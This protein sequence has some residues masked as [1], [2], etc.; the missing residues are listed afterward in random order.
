MLCRCGTCIPIGWEEF[1]SLYSSSEESANVSLVSLQNQILERGLAN[2]QKDGY[3]KQS[4]CPIRTTFHG[5]HVDLS[6]TTY[7]LALEEYLPQILERN[8]DTRKCVFIPNDA[9]SSSLYFV[10][11]ASPASAAS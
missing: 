6:T 9:R 5:V 3:T 7:F 2:L 10:L 11:E 1:G 8:G 4:N